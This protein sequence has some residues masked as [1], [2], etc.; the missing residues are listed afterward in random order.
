MFTLNALATLYSEM[1]ETEMA[2]GAIRQALKQSERSSDTFQISYVLHNAGQIEEKFGNN[3]SAMFFYRKA[4][5][6]RQNLQNS[7]GQIQ[8]YQSLATLFQKKGLHDSAYSYVAKAL[9]IA[10]NMNSKPDLL[11]SQIILA[12]I[13]LKQKQ[14]VNAE[15]YLRK[16]H[17]EVEDNQN[18]NLRK[19]VYGLFSEL[20]E[21]KG[22]YNK[23][24]QFA[25][26]GMILG[27]SLI[28]KNREEK[29]SQLTLVYKM[30]EKEREGKRIKEQAQLQQKQYD[31]NIQIVS[32]IAILMGTILLFL[33]YIFHKQSKKH[34]RQL[35]NAL[36]TQ[37]NLSRKI[38]ELEQK[39]DELGQKNEDIRNQEAKTKKNLRIKDET[40]ELLNQNMQDPIK[41][42]IQITSNLLAEHPL[43]QKQRTFVE[44]IH[45]TAKSLERNLAKVQQDDVSPLSLNY[46]FDA[47]NISKIASEITSYTQSKQTENKAIELV[48]SFADYP[49]DRQLFS[50]HEAIIKVM[51]NLI[52][53]AFE[54]ANQGIL[55][56]GF[57]VVDYQIRFYV[58]DSRLSVP[59]EVQTA[60]QQWQNPLGGGQN[61][62][63]LIKYGTAIFKAC[64]ITN[65]IGSFLSF[66]TS[67]SWGNMFYFVLPLR[68]LEN[69][70]IINDQVYPS[71][72]DKHILIAEDEYLNFEVLRNYIKPT[73]AKISHARNGQE[74]LEM[75]RMFK[76]DLI[77]MDIKMPQ[78][79]G[80]DAMQELKKQP[81]KVPVVA[82][83][84]HALASERASF[85]Q[86]G[87]A[88]FLLKPINKMELYQVID[89]L[90]MVTG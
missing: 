61:D 27:D 70:K 84:A 86:M 11:N 66:E 34:T 47:C 63:V 64:Q 7:F 13:L 35:A 56:M 82:Q 62:P 68:S 90:F 2:K 76:F 19:K 40:L 43:E 50:S 77:I 36:E 54:N 22:E 83:T 38:E 53:N 20:H 74:I 80:I 55:K 44:K 89:R 6:N 21:I 8:S 51:E 65:K 10:R 58:D 12:E 81:C 52:D 33:L 28:T 71:W 23:A 46:N 16:I 57:K 48:F 32:Y 87:F 25:R 30:D 5:S 60:L 73:K 17:P 78:M 4:L 24:L 18:P 15:L 1:N 69:M 79:D 49:N 29:I 75:I 39:N 9:E 72:Q 26:K 31:S 88:D 85:L 14:W 3:D 37:E 59:I 67:N 45:C 41:S 42:I